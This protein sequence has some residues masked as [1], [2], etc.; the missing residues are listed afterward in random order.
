MNYYPQYYSAAQ[1]QPTPITENRNYFTWIQGGANTAVAYTL[2]PGQTEAYMM[3]ADEPFLFYKTFMDGKPVTRMY[4]LVERDINSY[5]ANK[6]SEAQTNYLTKDDLTQMDF[7][8]KSDLSDF[9]KELQ[10]IKEEILDI[11]TTPDGTASKRR[12]AK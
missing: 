12:N 7:A 2:Q 9:I 8:T 3:D 1:L 11:Q 5:L 4:E 10:S 6:T